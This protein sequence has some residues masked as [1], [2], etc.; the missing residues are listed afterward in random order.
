MCNW[1]PNFIWNLCKIL[2]KSTLACAQFHK[3]LFKGFMTIMKK[4]MK[5]EGPGR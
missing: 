5:E 3:S 2:H 1:S 4:L